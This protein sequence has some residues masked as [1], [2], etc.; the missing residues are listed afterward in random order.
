MGDLGVARGSLA[1]GA[2]A[3]NAF[4]RLVLAGGRTRAY[5]RAGFGK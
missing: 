5:R 1:K 2:H 4:C 3:R